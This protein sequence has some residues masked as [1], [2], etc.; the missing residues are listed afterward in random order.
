VS[1][2]LLALAVCVNELLKL[3]VP[4]LSPLAIALSDVLA[5]KSLVASANTAGVTVIVPVGVNCSVAIPR[6]M[7]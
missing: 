2:I 6:I 7:P 1:N 5:V 4:I 3:A